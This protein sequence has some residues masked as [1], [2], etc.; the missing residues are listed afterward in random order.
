MEQEKLQTAALYIR[1]STTDQAE[2]SPDAQK[3]LL[4]NYAI[5]N[6]YTT[7][8]QYTFIDAGISGRKADTRP[9]F[10][11]MI[12]LAKK[13]PRP[14]DIILVHKFDRF[15]RSR[16]DSIVY[17]SMLKKDCGIKVISITESIEDDKFSVI[18]EAMLEAMA[19]Y[20]SINLA[21]EVTKGMTEKALRGGFQARPPLG[22]CIPYHNAPL[23]IVPEEAKI[24]QLI[25]H[26]Y[27]C[28]R[29]SPFDIARYLNHLGFK[30]NQG[31]T[32][33]RRTIEY[34]LQNPCYAGFTRWNRTKSSTSQVKDPSE[35]ITVKGQHPAII[36]QSLFQSAQEYLQNRHLNNHARPAATAKHW[37][38]GILKCSSCG[39]TLSSSVKYLKSGKSYVTFQCYG[40][41]KGKCSVSHFVTEKNIVPSVLLAIEDAVTPSPLS[42]PVLNNESEVSEEINLLESQLDK[43][44]FKELRIK[45]AYLQGIDTIQEYEANKHTLLHEKN[46]LIQLIQTKNTLLETSAVKTIQLQEIHTLYDLITSD[47]FTN[48]EKNI[49]LKSV[50][51]KIIYDKSSNHIDVYYRFPY[52][53]QPEE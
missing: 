29:S 4:I 32:F 24:I 34:I 39:R 38:S 53:Y 27:V 37:L 31:R 33:E 17:K 18:L 20:Y 21:E 40:Y 3:R 7:T 47:Y 50:V 46:A 30:T 35:W 16:E 14:F 44:S 2:L 36:S 5:Q 15:S 10:M 1:V 8:D 52:S 23:K 42:Y 45:D 51:S 22:Y 12:G 9:E 41:L 6:H 49:A 25:F 48:I 43:F 11:R 28:E 13:N 19:E 26:Q